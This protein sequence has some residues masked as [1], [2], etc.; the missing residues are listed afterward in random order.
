MKKAIW[1][2]IFFFFSAIKIISAQNLVP[3]PSFEEYDTCLGYI[4]GPDLIE[5][6]TTLKFWFNPTM[7]SPDYDNIC[8]SLSDSAYHVPKNVIGYQFPR[9]GHAYIDIDV[10][11]FNPAYHNW[12]YVE[13]KLLDS[14]LNGKK[15]CANF[16]VSL[17]D[18]VNYAIDNIGLYFSDTLISMATNYNLPFTPQIVNQPGSFLTDKINWAKISGEYIAHGGEKYIIIGNFSDLNNTDIL[19]VGYG[20]KDTTIKEIGYYIDDVSVMLCSDT[21]GIN[22]VAEDGSNINVYPNPTSDN[23]TVMFGN[24]D[25]D[26]CIFE[27]YDAIGNKVFS[28]EIA[29]NQNSVIIPLENVAK[30]V[31]ILKID[32]TQNTII[33]KLIKN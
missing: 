5:I 28:N 3:N 26:K 24:V 7:T 6:D 15:Y 14:L 2:F 30:G 17:A 19:H 31:Y 1:I 25:N 20:W 23:V 21:T 22:E 27:L 13:V 4:V 33:K 9:T 32:N 18:S 29:A 11:T 16:F 10:C 8:Y 12:E